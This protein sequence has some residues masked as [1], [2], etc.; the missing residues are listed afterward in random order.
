MAHEGLWKQLEKL[1][2]TETA[3]R[4]KCKYLNNP[5]RYLVV[6]LNTEYVIE[7]PNRK[8]F[9]VQPEMPKKPAEFLEQLCLL[10]YLINAQDIPFANKLV[11]A[12]TLPGGQ[13]FFRG[14]HSLPTVKLEINFGNY[15]E[16]LYQT[17]SQF[18]AKKCTY[19]DASI[20]L[21]V[22]P[23]I[24][25]TIVVWRGDEEF[26]TRASILFDK[27]AADQLP[28]DALLTA[29]NLTVEVLAKAANES[30]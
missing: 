19:G 16:T 14:Q 5:D 23:H 22:L 1:N 11:K 24:P 21:N 30:K 9:S 3:L 15:P 26:A 4:A 27:T 25:L 28:L 17:L 29:V 18:N 8:I 2:G 10:A 12:E 6:M 20:E 7:L 13:F